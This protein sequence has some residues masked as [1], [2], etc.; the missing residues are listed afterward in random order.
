MGGLLRPD[1]TRPGPP[2]LAAGMRFAERGPEP[3]ATSSPSASAEAP[4]AAVASSWPPW[5]TSSRPCSTAVGPTACR[6]CRPPRPGSC[7]CWRAR[8]RAPDEVVAVVPPDLVECTVEKVA[9]NAV[10]AGCL[11]EYLPVVLAAVEAA[12]TDE[13]NMHG[14]LATTY[15]SGPMIVVNGPLARAHRHEQRRQCARA[16]Q[17]GQ[18][19]D[20][21]GAPTGRPQRRWW[22]SGRRRPGH[23]RSPRQAQLLL[24]RGRGGLALGAVV[25]VPRR[26]ARGRHGDPLR[27]GGCRAASWTSSRARPTPWPGPWRPRCAARRIPSWSSASTP[28]SSSRP[29]TPGCSGGGLEPAAPDRRADDLLTVDGQELVRG[30][31]G[32]AEGLPEAFAELSLPKFRGGGL[33]VVHA[34]GRAGLFSAIIGG[35]VSGQGGSEPVTREIATMSGGP[36]GSHRRERTRPPRPLLDRPATLEGLTVG[37]LDISK[38][39]GD[40]F[41]DQLESHLPSGGRPSSASP[42]PPS[43]NRPQPTSATRSPSAA[44]S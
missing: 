40:I 38:P 37:L 9:V 36:A 8:S 43:P 21:S 25:G 7:A 10:M 16:G 5:R 6:S 12:C 33:L 30:A 19:D 26:R 3:R 20:R 15:F 34:G 28:S 23:A 14:L 31:G 2:R 22:P 35:W 11:P 41:L 32:I 4:C 17:P 29:S 39:R 42:S 27:R 18:P 13:F 1:R 24:R 44:T